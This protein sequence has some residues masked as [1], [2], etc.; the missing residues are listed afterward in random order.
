M[1]RRYPHD[2]TEAQCKMMRRVELGHFRRVGTG[3]DEVI[4]KKHPK[5]GYVPVTGRERMRLRQL[6]DKGSLIR[7]TNGFRHAGDLV[8]LVTYFIQEEYGN[9]KIGVADSLKITERL[10]LAHP[11]KIT[12]LGGF[13][14]DRSTEIR[15]ACREYHLNDGWY[16][17]HADVLAWTKHKDF[18]R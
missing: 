5:K 2:L 8:E 16:K 13:D 4:S 3:D 17:P 18:H 11:R 1:A 12:M 6:V 9:I 15:K 14:G 10:Q 7:T